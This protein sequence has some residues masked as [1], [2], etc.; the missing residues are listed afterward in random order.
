MDIRMGG[1]VDGHTYRR[2]DEQIRRCDLKASFHF[3]YRK[4]FENEITDTHFF[5]RG[6]FNRHSVFFTYTVVYLLLGSM[7]VYVLL[8]LMNTI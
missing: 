8:G 6:H 7:S 5:L 1:W 2:I 4:C 3:L